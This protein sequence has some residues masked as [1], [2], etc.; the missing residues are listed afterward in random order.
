MKKAIWVVVS[1]ALTVFGAGQYVK[2]ANSDLTD[3][4]QSRRS[5]LAEVR[6]ILLRYKLENGDFPQTLD[7][8]V[9]KYLPQVPLALQNAPDVEPV[10]RIRYESSGGLARFTYHVIRGPDSTEIFD[11]VGNS[12]QRNR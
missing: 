9:P 8:L 10:K 11:V 4:T 7:V 3:L 1:V 2:W 12:F 6:P 5:A